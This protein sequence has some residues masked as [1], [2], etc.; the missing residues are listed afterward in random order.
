MIP[1]LEQFL[2]AGW[3]F[4][5]RPEVAVLGRVLLV[6]FVLGCSI[7]AVLAIVLGFRWY[8]IPTLLVPVALLS[9]LYIRFSAGSTGGVDSDFGAV[10]A[11]LVILWAAVAW[12][13][14]SIVGFFVAPLYRKS[15]VT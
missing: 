13:V 5:T 11:T 7:Q 2:L 9:L 12:I 6:W 1:S 3:A 14:A 10:L 8:L 15:R 4:A